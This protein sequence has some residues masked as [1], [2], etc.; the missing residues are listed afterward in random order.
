MSLFNKK[1]MWKKPT[2]AQRADKERQVENAR[3]SISEAKEAA[4]Q[5]LQSPLFKDYFQ[6]LQRGQDGIVSLFASVSISDPMQEWKMFKELQQEY[7]QI[8]FL[9]R[10]VSRDA[11]VEIPESKEEEPA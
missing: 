1:A 3:K 11:S 4:A 7:V 5:C 10:A 6:K 8:G 9:L 2:P